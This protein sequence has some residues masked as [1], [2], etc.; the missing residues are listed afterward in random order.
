MTAGRQ[1]WAISLADSGATAWVC[2]EEALWCVTLDSEA[3]PAPPEMT[4]LPEPPPRLS[5]VWLYTNADCNLR[6]AHCLVPPRVLRPS[7]EALLSRAEEARALGATTVYLTGG[8]PFLRDDAEE[9]L[10]ELATHSAV[11]V[12]TNGT[13]ITPGRLVRLRSLVSAE[14]LARIAF[15]VSI[16]GTEVV[17]DARRG[18]NAYA[19]AVAGIRA[20]VDTGNA[21]A[22]ST[23]LTHE[24]LAC[25]P[26]VTRS[27]SRL[28]CRVHHL[29]L[30]HASG[31]L[32]DRA[33]AVPSSAELLKA[34]RRCRDVAAESGVVLSNHAA[35]ASRIRR[36]GR[37]FDGCRGGCAMM[38]VSAEGELYPC[39]SLIGYPE[40][41]DGADSTILDAMAT[42]RAAHLREATLRERSSCAVCEYRHFCGGGCAAHAYVAGGAYEATDPY[43]EVYRG[44][45]EDCL[46]MEAE[47]LLATAVGGERDAAVLMPAGVADTVAERYRFG[48]T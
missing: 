1:P 28:G 7:R 5:D 41:A 2:P 42:G 35:I 30:P 14:H 20:L 43:C 40:L 13:L 17:H 24:N 47:R 29:F 22:I 25:A 11:V 27:V 45:I 10:A 48:C 39:P 16:D 4:R 44:L 31:R 15:Q 21:P 38:V 6:C 37:R 34:I 33:S 19:R 3:P 12:L 23:V 18:R 36:P 8:E 46:R 9:L 32:A 26:E